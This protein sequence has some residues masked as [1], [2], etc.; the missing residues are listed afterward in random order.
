MDTCQTNIKTDILSSTSVFSIVGTKYT[1]D[2]HMVPS[3]LT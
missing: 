3:E 2:H 1:R